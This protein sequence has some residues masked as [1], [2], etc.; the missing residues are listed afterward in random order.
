MC[1]ETMENKYDYLMSNVQHA[2]LCRKATVPK[3]LAAGQAVRTAVFE[4]II[5]SR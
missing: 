2:H 3:A 4:I 5:C 1:E